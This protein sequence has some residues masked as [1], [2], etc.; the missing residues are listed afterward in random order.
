MV[1]KAKVGKLESRFVR[2]RLRV[3]TPTLK[4]GKYKG[5][6][7]PDVMRHSE[8]YWKR[9]VASDPVKFVGSYR[10]FLEMEKEFEACEQKGL[11]QKQK[12]D[13]AEANAYV[14]IPRYFERPHD[15]IYTGDEFLESSRTG[16]TLLREILEPQHA[17]ANRNLVSRY[18]SGNLANPHCR[19]QARYIL[20]EYQA[21]R[22]HY[23]NMPWAQRLPEHRSGTP[24][25]LTFAQLLLDGRSKFEHLKDLKKLRDSQKVL[26][27]N[28]SATG[29][30][31]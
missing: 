7:V 21:D 14:I 31:D 8:W 19:D 3:K 30:Q 2:K 17:V 29:V 6:S 11:E 10:L 5:D 23:S 4:H 27:A 12:R 24:Q 1:G 22:Y 26:N 25:P 15:H 16:A 20:Q 18:E 28:R 13:F 9:I